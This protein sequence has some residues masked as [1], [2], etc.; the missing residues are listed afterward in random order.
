M[1]GETITLTAAVTAQHCSPAQLAVQWTSSSPS[2]AAVT[3]AGVVTAASSGIAT[4]R[5]TA[6][7]VSDATVVLV[8]APVA[9]VEVTPANSTLVQGDSLQL[10][11]RLRDAQGNVLTARTITWQ[12]SSPPN[13]TVSAS[14]VVTAISPAPSVTIV[15][16]SAGKSGTATLTIE[17]PPRLVLDSAHVAF[18]EFAGGALPATATITIRNGGGG[19]LA[20]LSVHSVR[21]TT[22]TTGWLQATLSATSATPTATLSLRVTTSSLTVGRHAATVTIDANAQSAPQDVEVTVDVTAAPVG[23]VVVDPATLLVA[24]GAKQT[25]SATVRDPAGAILQGVAV[26]WSSTNPAVAAIDSVTGL[27]TAAAVGVATIRATAGGVTGSGFAYTGTAS[28]FDGVWRGQA[29]SG[30]TFAMTVL[31]GRV[32]SL[33]ISVGTPP[34]SPCALTYSA[35][36][37]TL[38]SGNAFAFSTAGATSNATVSGSFLSNTSAQGTYGTIT[39]DRYVCPP[40]LLV[41]G[42]VTGGSWSAAKQ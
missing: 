20:G 40:N 38:V 42:T 7:G 18:S 4:V 33:S 10:T 21:Y 36:P 17:P 9:T 25:M 12:S 27:L 30:R 24:V 13:A 31:Y 23:S 28:S 15:A 29:G 11:A 35:S 32:A 6:G 26:R 5:A 2:V 8:E 14:G 22:P 3:G 19:T 39:F 1:V 34:G 41:N 16:T 37:L